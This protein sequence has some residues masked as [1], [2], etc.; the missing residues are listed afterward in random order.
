V[1]ED[2]K[3]FAMAVVKRLNFTG[4]IAFDFISGEEGTFV[5]ECNPRAT[6]GVFLLDPSDPLPFFSDHGG[7]D[8]WPME[9][10]PKMLSQGMRFY[11]GRRERREDYLRAT[12]AM[13]PADDRIR[14][15][16]RLRQLWELYRRSKQLDNGYDLIAAATE[17]FEWNGG[18]MK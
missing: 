13:F 14:L 7:P 9:L 8:R 4:Q 6:S 2:L 1:R 11:P 18:P 3:E 5:I 10:T 17:D 12:D 16:P 15:L